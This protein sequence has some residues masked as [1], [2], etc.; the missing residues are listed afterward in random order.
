MIARMFCAAA[1][2]LGALSLTGCGDKKAEAPKPADTNKVEKAK[3]DAKDAAK[4]AKD[5]KDAAKGAKDAAKD[6]KDA[7][8]DAKKEG[9]KQ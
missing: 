5:A 8:K 7:A 3:A 2:V 4:D 9:D 6:A 1:L